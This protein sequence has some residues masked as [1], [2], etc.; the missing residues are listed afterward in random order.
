[1]CVDCARRLADRPFRADPRPRPHRLP[2]VWAAAPYDGV[3]RA[4]IIAHKEQAALALTPLLGRA[5]A[6]SAVACLASAEHQGLDVMR[7]LIVPVPSRAAVV[8]ARGHDPVLRMARVAAAR[9]REAGLDLAVA[10]LLHVGRRV[11]DQASLDRAERRANMRGSMRGRPPRGDQRGRAA[12]VVDDIVTTG[13]TAAEAARALRAVRV[14]VLG[15]A[16]VAATPL[17]ADSR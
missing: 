17:R 16:V 15:I 13:A 1:M 8:R 5:L 12:V 14:R 3:A 9:L 11:R 6:R 10:P 7:P 2:D 4:A